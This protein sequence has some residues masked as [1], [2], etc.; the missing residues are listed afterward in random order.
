[1]KL[2]AEENEYLAA[3]SSVVAPTTDE[4]VQEKLDGVWAEIKKRAIKTAQSRAEGDGDVDLVEEEVSSVIMRYKGVF[5]INR[6]TQLHHSE[7][8]QPPGLF[9]LPRTGVTAK[10]FGACSRVQDRF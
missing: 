9:A 3:G 1:M 10:V 8:P 4:E 7:L 2:A 5:M 6:H